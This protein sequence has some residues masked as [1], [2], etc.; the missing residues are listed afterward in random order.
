MA[1]VVDPEGYLITNRHVIEDADHIESVTFSALERPITYSSVEIVYIDPRRD[2]ALLK[3]ASKEPLPYLKVPSSEGT[4]RAAN[5]LATR[6]PVMLLSRRDVHEDER[7]SDP[8]EAGLVAHLGRVDRLEVYNPTVGPGPYLAISQD[9]QQGQSGGP[10]LDRYGRAVGVVTWTWR[11]RTGGFAIPIDEAARMIGE[12]PALVTIEQ[13]E[14]RA[15]ER[16]QQ[17]LD[18]LSARQLDEARRLTSPTHARQVRGRTVEFMVERASQ[19][20]AFHEYIGAL[21]ELLAQSDPFE[22]LAD[23]AMKTGSGEFRATMGLDGRIS[24]ESV[25]AFFFEFGQAY[26]AARHFG[27]RNAAD[28]FDVAM[29]RIHS[30]D[31]ARS[32][33][34]A[35]LMRDVG[36]SLLAI[37]SIELV[38]S[39]TCSASTA[40][41]VPTGCSA[42]AV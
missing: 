10:V 30:L 26:V 12:R 38:P 25:M 13:Q 37:E 9:V 28:A 33:V 41:P 31:A 40:K 18:A 35:D 24:S 19:T 7:A 8:V 11:D 6:D 20:P 2:L 36:E 34:L 42:S 15:R 17:F 16:T 5:Y 27:Q 22:A 39:A 29:Q 32:F 1:F 23:V 21:E 14:A 3:I 4:K